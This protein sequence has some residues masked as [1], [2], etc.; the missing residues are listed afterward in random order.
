MKGERDMKT[1]KAFEGRSDLNRTLISAYKKAKET[2]NR[3]LDFYDVVWD[4]DIE[5]IVDECRKAGVDFITISS[6]QSGM[7]ETLVKF[8]Q[9]GC[10]L[11]MIVQVKAPYVDFMTG[12]FKEVPA[13]A[14]KL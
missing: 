3:Y 2:G 10:K 7:M 11:E 14:I 9:L 8:Q 13:M 12:E 5:A 4:C 6:S 1:V